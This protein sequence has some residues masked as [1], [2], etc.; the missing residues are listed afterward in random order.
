MPGR[1]CFSVNEKRH[2]CSARAEGFDRVPVAH[3]PVRRPL[4]S[5]DLLTQ[6]VNREIAQGIGRPGARDNPDETQP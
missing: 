1:I 2:D 4:F 3:D 5:A 6:M